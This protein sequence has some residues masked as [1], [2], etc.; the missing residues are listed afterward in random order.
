[1]A[2]KVKVNEDLQKERNRCSFNVEE[3]T[4]FIDGSAKETADR[5][6]SENKILSIKELKDVVP[7]EYLSHKEKYEN[8]IRKAV[9][10]YAVLKEMADKDAS[11]MEMARSM[12]ANRTIPAIFKDTSPFTL[13]FAMFIPTIIGQADEKQKEYWLKR[14]I[15]MEI[16]GTYAQTELGHGTFIRGLETSATYD[17]KTEEFVL[18][19]PTLTS[20]KWWPGNLGH[21]VNYCV[22]MARLYTQ[23]KDCGI[24]PFM[25]QVRDEETHIPLRGIKIGEIGAK[26]G[27]NTANNGFLGFD[28]LRIPRDR[29]LMKNAQV[30]K[31]GT[32][33]VSPNSKLTYGTMVFVRVMIVNGVAN[34]LARVAT[35]AVRYSAVRRQ[36]QL[37]PNEPE[38][39][40]L[41]YLTQQHKLFI[42]IASSHAYTNTA[43]WLWNL[44][45]KV[46]GELQAG[47]LDHLPELHSLAC[48]LKAVST[49]DGSAMAERCRLACGGHGYM[50]SSNLPLI[51]GLVTAAYTLEGEF[52]V[53]MLQTAR[54]LVKAY[55]QAAKGKPY[56]PTMAYLGDKTPLQKWDGSVDCIAKS[57]QKI[58]AGKVASCV[59]NINKYKKSGLCPEDAWNMTSVQ[60]VAASE[61]HCRAII[62]STYKSELARRSASVSEP[63][64]VVLN[65]LV[66]LYCVYWAL[67]KVGDLLLYTAISE[68]DIQELQKKY[69]ALLM[70]IRPNAV[71]LVDAFD[72][73]DEILNSALGAYDGRVYERLM[74]EALKSP[75]NAQPVNETFHKYLKPFM[76]GK[77]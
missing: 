50:M 3:L 11:E 68:T 46:S 22:V 60:L 23:G 74:E 26:L 65:Q 53:L 16:I 66:E 31:D 48:C 8:A 33:K 24:Q 75:L 15:N 70:L 21:T 19:S 67:E 36:S 76:Q 18:H 34:L 77:L 35:I 38:P 52:T 1:M 13:H 17:P 63:L 57:F 58:A 37:K 30:L 28:N 5:R 44:Y 4:N 7:E 42:A 62:L 2:S 45:S 6:K 14:A 32:F 10:L 49:M 41:D 29:M 51:Y 59:A 9:K 54:S 40:I 72:F 64:K 25:V 73:R 39:Q 55:E 47:K 20:Y 56:S 12:Y 61:A 43:K 71:G 27:Y 69:E